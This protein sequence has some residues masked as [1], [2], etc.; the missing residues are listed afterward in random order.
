MRPAEKHSLCVLT[1]QEMAEADRLTIEAGIDGSTLMEAA[2]RAV[3]KTVIERFER[4]PVLV[5]CGPGNNGGDGYAV[6]FHLKSL[7]WPVRAVSPDPA[8]PMTGEAGAMKTRW[9]QAA[10]K[11]TPAISPLS[12]QAL[13][14]A[15][16]VIDALFGAGLAREIGGA[17][18]EF[19]RA[20]AASGLPVVAVDVPSGVCGTTGTVRGIAVPA[21]VTVTFFRKKPGHVLYPG[22]SLCGALALAQIGIPDSVLDTLSTDT[23][24]N[25]P[26]L[27]TESWPQLPVDAHKYSRGACLVLGGGLGSTGAARLASRS[28]L[29]AGAGLVQTGVRA[30]GL[31]EC[32]SHQT[33]VMNAVLET[34]DDLVELL[35]A[36][37]FRS[38]VVGPGMGPGRRARALTL[39]LLKRPVEGKADQRL[40]LVLDA[41]ALTS[42]ASQADVLFEALHDQVVLTPHWGEANRLFGPETIERATDK[43]TLTRALASQARATVVLKGPDTVIASCDGR[44]AINTNAPASLATAG[45]GDV[46]AGLIGGLLAQGMPAFEAACAGVWLHGGAAKAFGPGL[47]AEDLSEA[48]PGVLR[49]L[50]DFLAEAPVGPLG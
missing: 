39:A 45:A 3:V 23:F 5:A 40:P 9:A 44:A 30:D 16:L 38:A 43:L 2:A 20:L 34:P 31:A 17:T 33:A 46:L 47:I 4:Q 1:S 15:E 14:D 50:E 19:L 6:A 12:A 10:L 28:A 29:R 42:F 8:A 35:A 24:E 13:E 49:G 36:R 22:R 18:A 41:D 26:A 37:R 21:A 48:L 32:A 11:G 7:G 27:W 25:A